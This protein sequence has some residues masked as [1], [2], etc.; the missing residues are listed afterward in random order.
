MAY[1]SRSAP[2]PPQP[3]TTAPASCNVRQPLSDTHT[4]ARGTVAKGYEDVL[5]AN[6]ELESKL[7]AAEQALAKARRNPAPAPLPAP[8][9]GAGN[10]LLVQYLSGELA[11]SRQSSAA[12]ESELRQR[13]R[14]QMA[15]MMAA[16][17]SAHEQ[18]QAAKEEPR[19]NPIVDVLREGLTIL[20]PLL[21]ARFSEEPEWEDEP[22][23]EPED[24]AQEGAA[25]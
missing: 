24:D 5:K 17:Q 15:S 6:I 14:E 11:A 12:L 7:Q 9:N 19:Q 22:E 21:L 13:D 3:S 10:A 23:D 20:S 8:A 16:L 4:H 1:P 18:V 2:A 25:A